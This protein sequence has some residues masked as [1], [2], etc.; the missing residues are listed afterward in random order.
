MKLFFLFYCNFFVCDFVFFRRG[1]KFLFIILTS[2]W[3]W[4]KKYSHLEFF[5]ILN[6]IF[7]ADS[8]LF[9]RLN[10]HCLPTRF[11]H[12][13]SNINKHNILFS[14]KIYITHFES[15]WK[16]AK[17]LMKIMQICLFFSLLLCV[18]VCVC[19]C[20]HFNLKRNCLNSSF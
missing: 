4:L 1:E 9:C 19:M 10:F 13:F 20:L 12:F 5:F 7:W 18:C 17:K 11:S 2:L 3:S 15:R 6:I 16:T 14:C 8:F